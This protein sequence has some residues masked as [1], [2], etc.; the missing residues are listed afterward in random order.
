MKENLLV[1]AMYNYEGELVQEYVEANELVSLNELT[2]GMKEVLVKDI[3]DDVLTYMNKVIAFEDML[4]T[5]SKIENYHRNNNTFSIDTKEN[6]NED[7]NNLFE[8]DDILV[9]LTYS[10]EEVRDIYKIGDIVFKARNVHDYH[11]YIEVIDDKNYSKFA[12]MDKILYDINSDRYFVGFLYEGEK[13]YKGMIYHKVKFLSGGNLKSK[14][15]VE[16]NKN[17]NSMQKNPF[18]IG[19]VNEMIRENIIANEIDLTSE[20]KAKEYINNILDDIESIE[21]IDKVNYIDYILTSRL[22]FLTESSFEDVIKKAFH[23]GIISGIFNIYIEEE[24]E[25]RIYKARLD[26]KNSLEYRVIIFKEY[27]DGT[28]TITFKYI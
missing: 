28:N 2:D 25:C 10:Y 1:T 24:D 11:L 26:I 3:N 4:K 6:I 9:G 7:I 5:N 14:Y 23:D 20:K 16:I 19:I 18:V 15:Y 12:S 22:G 21:C 13:E 17:R 8:I 27:Y